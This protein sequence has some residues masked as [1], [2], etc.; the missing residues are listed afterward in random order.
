MQMTNQPVDY[1]TVKKEDIP[2]DIYSL[3]ENERLYFVIGEDD[4][5]VRQLIEEGDIF[6]PEEKGRVFLIT[7]NNSDVDI[8]S[9]LS[10][11]ASNYR[12][13]YYVKMLLDDNE[14]ENI[15]EMLEQA[16]PNIIILKQELLWKI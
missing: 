11:A 15:L 4:V 7:Y 10:E 2:E 13:L 3:A 1:V 12:N 9:L 5:R 8:A 6:S 16:T 14:A